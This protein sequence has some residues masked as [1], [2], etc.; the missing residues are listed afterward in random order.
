MHFFSIFFRYFQF[1]PKFQTDL[2]EVG[3]TGWDS[4][5]N[6]FTDW[7]VPIASTFALFVFTTFV[8]ITAFLCRR[9]SAI[10]SRTKISKM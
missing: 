1:L 9:Q 5:W 4:F 2:V 8:A 10:R 6:S 3:N 7:N